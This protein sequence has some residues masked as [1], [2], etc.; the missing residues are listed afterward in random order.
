MGLKGLVGLQG[1]GFGVWGLG[2]PRHKALEAGERGGMGLRG[3]HLG[4]GF[5]LQGLGGLG[6][7]V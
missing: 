1:F 2:F 4:S 7:R 5:G 3:L 6:L